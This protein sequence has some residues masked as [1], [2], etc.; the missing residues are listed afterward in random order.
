[1]IMP[2]P[3]SRLAKLLWTWLVVLAAKIPRDCDAARVAA[4]PRLIQGETASLDNSTLKNKVSVR[5]QGGFLTCF[6]IDLV[7]KGETLRAMVDSGSTDT[8][9]PLLGINNYT[10]PT[11]NQRKPADSNITSSTFSDG[12]RWV[13]FGAKTT[14]SLAGTS[15]SADNAPFIGVT[16]QSTDPLLF[17]SPLEGLIGI[18]YDSLS[19]YKTSE[20]IQSVLGAWY[21]SG[22]MANDEIAFHGCPYSHVE[23]SYIDIGNTEP[24]TKC[25]PTGQPNV[26]AASPVQDFYTVDIR[27]IYIDG[28]PIPLPAGFQDPRGSYPWSLVD[29]CTSAIF[30]PENVHTALISAIK[31]SGGLPSEVASSSVVD[32][33]L[34]AGVS[35][36]PKNDFD[37]AKMPTISF[38]FLTEAAFKAGGHGTF[39]ITLGPRQYLQRDVNGFYTFLALPNTQ[40]DSDFVLFGVPLFT[41]L[42]I[43]LDRHRGRV[44]FSM[45]CGCDAAKQEYPSIQAES[46]EVW[47]PTVQT[48]VDVGNA[49]NAP[50]SA[51][52]PSS[53][54]TEALE[55]TGEAKPR[56]ATQ[57]PPTATQTAASSASRSKSSMIFAI[58]L[59][60]VIA[61][62][63]HA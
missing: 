60:L 17:H 53:L 48:A 13:G 35:L 4:Y 9:V 43:V 10:G 14:V 51:N 8:I 3:G 1:M 2:A 24:S 44:G 52:Q 22:A 6:M 38:D 18:A 40:Y 33:F 42:N 26:W 37:W 47:K 19:S 39:R 21:L 58:V 50:S 56:N 7:V 62:F 23:D 15:V 54:V 36:R 5:L 29:S 27:A 46:G 57:L 41:N 11:V 25:N 59:P 12:S 61:I 28:K 45:G 63:L 32:S 34:N 16:S 20:G 49:D 55:P 30:I 31:A